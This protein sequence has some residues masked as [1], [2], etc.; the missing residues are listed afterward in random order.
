M[1]ASPAH[2]PWEK[3]RPAQPQEHRASTPVARRATPL[4]P[5]CLGTK[6]SQT[7]TG[8]KLPAGTSTQQTDCEPA[9]ERCQ[10]CQHRTWV[11]SL[12]SCAI[13]MLYRGTGAGGTR[14]FSLQ[15]HISAARANGDLGLRASGEPANSSA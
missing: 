5:I 13:R 7:A 4:P 8:T 6:C 3:T 9:A 14:F 10:H 12:I 15:S 1:A 2:G 11:S